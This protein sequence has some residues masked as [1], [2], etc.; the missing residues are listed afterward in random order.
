M[1]PPATTATTPPT[2]SCH[3]KTYQPQQYDDTEC[4]SYA[5][6][7][8]CIP[9]CSASPLLA[10]LAGCIVL[11]CRIRFISLK[12]NFHSS[13]PLRAACYVRAPQHLSSPFVE[14]NL[15]LNQETQEPGGCR[16]VGFIV[17]GVS[18]LM[19]MVL[20]EPVFEKKKVGIV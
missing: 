12:P 18:R 6:R 14:L 8:S 7:C 10:S 2:P 19:W 13:L 17:R 4:A 9:A 20:M 1:C 15:N 11:N 16:L 5:P 3:Y